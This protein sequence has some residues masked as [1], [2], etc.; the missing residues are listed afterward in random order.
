[1]G[2]TKKVNQDSFCLKI[3]KTPNAN[4]VFVILCDGMGGLKNGELASSWVVNAFSA[5]FESELPAELKRNA[6]FEQIKNRW[7]I[8]ANE[9]NQK[10]GNYGRSNGFKLGTTLTAVLIIDN[11][12][13]IIHVGDTRIYKINDTI[14]QL[15]KD[16]TVVAMEVEKHRLTQEQAKTDARKNELLQC[17][18]A[19]PKVIPD[20][21]TGTLSE[22]DVF[23]LCSDGFRHEVCDEELFGILASQLLTSENVMKKCLVDLIN[24]N[25]DRKEQDNITALLIKAIK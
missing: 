8:I 25:K 6:T 2:I 17:V 13:L 24:L 5:W 4:I 21:D 10:I 3:A 20:Y 19:S 1:M 15:T 18:G 12:F 9:Q 7:N 16:Q 14:T 22:N 23:L 11:K